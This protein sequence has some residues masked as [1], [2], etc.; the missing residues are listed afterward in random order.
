MKRITCILLTCILCFSI[1]GCTKTYKGTDELIEKA[2]EEIPVYDAETINAQIV[3][4][5]WS[6][7]LYLSMSYFFAAKGYEGFASWMKAQAHEESD[8]ADVLA[9][10][11]MKRG[12]QAKVGAVDAVPQEW[13][14]PL[15]VF[16]HV[17][18]HECHVSELID[19]LVDVA[20]AEK[21]KASQDF[22]WGFVREQ[23]EEEA[24]VQGILDKIK[25]GGDVALYHLDI[26]LG[27]RK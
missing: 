24:T 22:L 19:K 16:E 9:Q 23:V 17:Y 14:S 3:A 15:D 10:Y 5:M 25:L 2:R 13:A 4:E 1:S 20:S 6:A 12:G 18:K 21:D 27:A 11:V 26:Q 7:N 8:H